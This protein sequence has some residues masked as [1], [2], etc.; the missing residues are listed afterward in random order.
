MLKT[1]NNY[2][3]KCMRPLREGEI[4]P[5]CGAAEPVNLPAFILTPGTVL[6]NRY[7]VGEPLGQDSHTITY[8]GFDSVLQIRVAVKEFFPGS[9]VNRNVRRSQSVTGTD[10]SRFEAGRQRFLYDARVLA[11]F[12]GNGGIVDV[13]DTFEANNTAYI[14]TEYLEGN[15]LQYVL[16]YYYFS[17]DDIFNRMLPIFN[18]LEALH[19]ENVFHLDISPE[20]VMMLRDGTLKLMDFGAVKALDSDTKTDDTFELKPGYTPLEQYQSDEPP[21]PWTDVYAL[22]AVIFRCITGVEPEN[23]LNRIYND[24]QRMPSELGIPISPRQEAVNSFAILV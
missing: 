19:L 14:V 10:K 12:S 9:Y 16:E 23:A 17:A 1:M 18:A 2:C 24:R 21:G 11:H 5:D 22:C 3:F 8:I 4:C 13:L 20:S 7:L 6:Q 15:N